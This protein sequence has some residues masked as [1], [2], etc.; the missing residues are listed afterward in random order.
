[1]NFAL[2]PWQ[3]YFLC[4]AGWINEE[5]QKIIEYLIT[6]NQILKEKLGKKRILLND[7]Q[8]CRLAVKGKILGRKALKKIATFFTPDTILRWHQQLVAQKWDYSDRF[9]LGRPHIRQ[10][11]VDLVVRFSRE[12][13]RWGYKRIE[14]ALN[15][16][17]YKIAISTIANILKAHGIEPAP[18]REKQTTWHTVLKAHWD[19]LGAI[20]FSTIEVWT[21]GG[22]VTYY[23]LFVIEVST[24]R[25]HFA[26][27]T[28][29][30]LS[31]WNRS[32]EI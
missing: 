18:G 29:K 10:K 20:D 25:V 9:K 30:H 5:Q 15:N 26:G 3:I 19:C 1:M 32:P 12:N 14:G 16:V 13:P 7:D 11:I 21:K 31:G 6:E 2:Q 17:G 27:C 8:R 22:L 4:L 28:P 24:R 23:L